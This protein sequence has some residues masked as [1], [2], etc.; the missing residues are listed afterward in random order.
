MS[1]QRGGRRRECGVLEVKCRKQ[2]RSDALIL[3]PYTHHVSI[4]L[5][6]QSFT[7]QARF[8]GLL[9]A[10]H[11]ARG[12]LLGAPRGE[13]RVC[14][15]GWGKLWFTNLSCLGVTWRLLQDRLPVDLGQKPRSHI[16]SKFPGD[17]ACW[18]SSH[19]ALRTR[20]TEEG[21]PHQGRLEVKALN[22]AWSSWGW[23][24]GGGGAPAGAC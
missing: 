17:A 2:R 24:G 18:W 11:R 21:T 23:G 15:W 20:V 9:P 14:V 1:D 13:F 3:H 8:K 7:Q 6:S 16:S 5:F 22:L 4:H 19:Y 10:R 12:T